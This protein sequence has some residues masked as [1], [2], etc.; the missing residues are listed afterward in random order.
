[1]SVHIGIS[2]GH[3]ATVAVL[4]DGALAFLQSE[5][6]LNRIK[7]ST[8]FP[9]Q[10]LRYVY[11]AVCPPQEVS[12]CTIFSDSWDGFEWLTKHA[13]PIQYGEYLPKGLELDNDPRI[14]SAAI[15]YRE[16]AKELDKR[17]AETLDDGKREEARRLVAS[18]TG[19]GPDKIRFANHHTAHALSCVPFIDTDDDVLIFTLDGAGDYLSSTVW[20]LRNGTLEILSKSAV[21]NSLGFIYR[22]VTGL[23]GLKMDEHEYKVMG[24]APYAKPSYY[25][26]IVEELHKLL[27][28]DNSGELR[29]K[30]YFFPQTAN[31]LYKIARFE[32][33]DNIAGATQ[34]FT[35]EI[36]V[37]WVRHWVRKTGIRKIACS[38]GVFMNVK[39]NQ[40]VAALDEVESCSV[41]PSC[42]D[43]S[44]SIGCAIYG[45]SL[46]SPEVPIRP[47]AGIYLGRAYDDREVERAIAD[48]GAAERYHISRPADINRVVAEHLARG[49]VVARCSGRME[50]GARALGNRS[51]LANPAH[52]ETVRFIN[53]AVKNRDFWMPF[54]PSMLADKAGLYLRNG[55]ELFSPYM[56]FAFDSTTAG[57]EKLV[58]AMHRYDFTL[59]A[60]MVVEDW[61]PDYYDVIRKF[62]DLT[63]VYGVLNTSFN[64]HGEPVV[65]SPGDAIST[66]D[67][68][69][70]VYCCID[71]YFLE[72][73]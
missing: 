1:M 45:N 14:Y 63:G 72:K 34:Q 25:Q 62:G 30:Y 20:C 73:R 52:L 5:E 42:G 2:H 4:R 50:F 21:A 33:F 59:R 9:A 49:Q 26:K 65:C 12:S 11:D 24:L 31:M 6:R 18:W 7:N 41:V 8:G 23:L 60:Q 29:A 19:L 3:N 57:Q 36:M 16:M 68:S 38:G 69:G 61:N 55:K 70:L 58:A 64:L 27:W 32:R 48:T 37:A 39:A 35:E 54:A 40:A 51:I 22:F 44:T 10:T 15:G 66:V 13:T 17:I 47:A 46:V 56:M 53:E 67:R 28:V 43:E 71:G